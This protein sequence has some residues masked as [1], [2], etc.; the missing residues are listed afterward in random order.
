MSIDLRHRG[1]VLS[2]MR[3][4]EDIARSLLQNFQAND[5]RA[6]MDKQSTDGGEIWKKE[7]REQLSEAG[8]CISIFSKHYDANPKRAFF[9]E[10][11]LAIEELRRDSF[12]LIP[13]RLESCDI[14]N[15]EIGSQ[16]GLADLHWVDLF[17]PHAEDSHI[18]LL[19]TLGAENPK[20]LFGPKSEIRFRSWGAPGKSLEV[21]VIAN[22]QELCT[23]SPGG[24]T[25]VATAAASVTMYARVSSSWRD[26]S[27][28]SFSGGYD[29]GRSEKINVRLRP[30]AK[31]IAHIDAR[32]IYSQTYS[33][34]SIIGIL[35]RK[36]FG[37]ED[38]AP[39]F[40]QEET[41]PPTIKMSIDRVYPE[42]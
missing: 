36:L 12:R 27:G 18:S 5:I 6:W 23:I 4:D 1:L 34:L 38:K 17:G 42:S 32:H 41:W 30:F 26:P 3:E 39:D 8:C 10:L 29:F 11:R 37:I 28:P 31:Y 7:F 19:K 24:E 35:G 13:V 20:V 2:Y 14:P 21:K 33:G 40:Y 16:I 22:G 25:L 9:Q 15:L